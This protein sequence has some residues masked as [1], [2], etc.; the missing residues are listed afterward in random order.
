MS[1]VF[2]GLYNLYTD[3]VDVRLSAYRDET[4]W[5]FI[6][7]FLG[8]TDHD[9]CPHGGIHNWLY[10]FGNCL[11]GNIGTENEDCICMT[12][13]GLEGPTFDEEYRL[14]VRPEAK[15]LRIRGTIIPIDISPAALA[16][17][18]II[19]EMDGH[20]SASDLL[21]ILDSDYRELLLATEEELR[22]RI[23]PDLPLI[24]RLNEWRHP[25]EIPTSRFDSR[26]GSDQLSGFTRTFQ[27]LANVLV[28][29]D[30]SLY[31]PVE[32][33]N[34]PTWNISSKRKVEHF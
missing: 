14:Q 3:T 32:E 22:R 7:E 31:Q 27:M 10:Y 16:T 24:L 23:P 33:P 30:P 4:R 19:P 8:V 5:A 12:D 28:S 34:T 13:D 26:F 2:P 1:D 18:E 20:M 21:R 15:T 17:K 25:D 29:G 6:I 11:L 9:W